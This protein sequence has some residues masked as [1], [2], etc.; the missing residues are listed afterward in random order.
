MNGWSVEQVFAL[1][2]AGLVGLGLYGVIVSQDALRRIVAFNVV[3][4]GVFLFFG[5]IARRGAAAGFAGDPVPQALIIT[6][7]VVA[8]AATALAVALLTR[9]YELRREN[10]TDRSEGND[11]KEDRGDG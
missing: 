8:F 3:G 7:I 4:G 11:R 2:A 1:C 10:L 5:A 9:W 6:G